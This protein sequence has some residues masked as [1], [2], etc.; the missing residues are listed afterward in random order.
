MNMFTS[1]ENKG[2]LWKLMS[3]NNVFGGLPENKYSQVKDIFENEIVTQSK[4]MIG[5]TLTEMNKK[6]LSEVTK[7]LI[8][9]R[10]IQNDQ[11][12]NSDISEQ[13][14]MKFS[15]NLAI[16]QRE[17]NKLI[18]AD[19]PSEID[20]SDDLNIN[21]D[22]ST[23]TSALEKLDSIISKR[24]QQMNNLS[25]SQDSKTASDWI[26]IRNRPPKINIGAKIDND[27]SF[28]KP[29]VT[30]NDDI[31]T[32][33]YNDSGSD[34]EQSDLNVFLSQLNVSKKDIINEIKKTYSEISV[35]MKIMDKLIKK[36]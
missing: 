4:I 9:L 18:N 5:K 31:V 16:R 29:R 34:D 19:K 7:K 36:L 21:D 3:E 22:L 12:S 8:P 24:E 28:T 10:V 15:D 26:G 14:Q 11:I 35:R 17:F 33:Q 6:V 30:F 1:N 13:R 20:F 32:E 27:E 23:E 2:L 25:Y